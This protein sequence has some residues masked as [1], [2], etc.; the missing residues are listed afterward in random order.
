VA[1]KTDHAFARKVSESEGEAAGRRYDCQFFEVS[2]AESFEHVE[3]VMDEMLRLCKREFIRKV[4][5]LE[6]ID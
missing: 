3:E 2:V 4:A 6:I 1:N 5:S